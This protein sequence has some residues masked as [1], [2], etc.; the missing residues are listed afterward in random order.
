MALTA[1]VKEWFERCKTC[2]YVKL[3]AD[4]VICL[5]KGE[6]KYIKRKYV[7]DA[8]GQMRISYGWYVCAA[9]L[10]IK[11]SREMHRQQIEGKVFWRVCK[12]CHAKELKDKPIRP[13][14]KDNPIR[15]GRKPKPL[16]K[17][18][19]EDYPTEKKCPRCQQVKSWTEFGVRTDVRFMLRGYC[20]ECY[21]EINREYSRRRKKNGEQT[22]KT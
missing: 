20:R 1:S 13:E 14:R 21:R 9:C 8:L 5:K 18:P 15:P 2:I 19:R 10:K 16:P 4:E 6:C 3:E 22:N 11:A 7:P 12:E 17:L